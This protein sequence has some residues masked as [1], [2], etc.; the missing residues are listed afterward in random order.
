MRGPAGSVLLVVL[1]VVLVAPLGSYLALTHA[2]PLLAG[3]TIVLSL[4]LLALGVEAARALR[5]GRM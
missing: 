3:L 5:G 1:T 2:G 4:A